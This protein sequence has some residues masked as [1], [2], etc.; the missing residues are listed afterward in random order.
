MEFKC[1]LCQITV[2]TPENFVTHF[3][4]THRLSSKSRFLCGLESCFISFL[5]LQKYQSHLSEFHAPCLNDAN[6]PATSTSSQEIKKFKCTFSGCHYECNVAST[7]RVHRKRK[8]TS[9][10]EENDTDYEAE[11]HFKSGSI[12]HEDDTVLASLDTSPA[13]DDLPGVFEPLVVDVLPTIFE[14]APMSQ[15]SRDQVLKK[16]FHLYLSLRATYHV[17]ESS[18]QYL[19]DSHYTLARESGNILIDEL[20]TNL[21][22]CGLEGEGLL[23]TIRSS[24]FNQVALQAHDPKGPLRSRYI[25]QKTYTS[26]AFRHVKPRS[27]KLGLNENNDIRKFH[28]VSIKETIQ[29]M[30]MDDSVFEQYVQ[31]QTMGCSSDDIIRDIQDGSLFKTHPVLSKDKAAIGV[32]MYE[33]DL[34][35]ADALKAARGKHK[36]T[37][38]EFTLSNLRP[39][40]RMKKGVIKLALLVCEKDVAYFGLE[41]A[42]KPLLDELKELSEEGIEIRGTKVPFVLAM[43]LGD[44]LGTH[45]FTGFLENFS[46]AKF[47]CRFCEETRDSWK[48]RWLLPEA[49]CESSDEECSSSEDESSSD[50]CDDSLDED[51]V[52]DDDEEEGRATSTA[53]E[54]LSLQLPYSNAPLRTPQ[55]YDQCL[56]DLQKRPSV[57]SVKGVVAK[58]LLNEVKNF[59]CIGSSP[60]C[61][62]HDMFEGV[63]SHDVALALKYF[64]KE[65]SITSEY[66]NRRIKQLKLSGSDQGDRP[67]K[68]TDKMKKLRGGAVQNW[69]F[70]RFLPL[71]IGNKIVRKSDPVW[72]MIL[73]LIELSRMLTSPAMPKAS[74]PKLKQKIYMYLKLR[75]TCFPDVPLRPKHHYLEHYP[76]LIEMFGCLMRVGTLTFESNHRFFKN[77]AQ[78]KKNF[79][80]I[81]KTLSEEHELAQ[82]ALSVD[83]LTCNYPQVDDPSSY[84]SLIMSPEIKASVESFFGCEWLKSLSCSEKVRFHGVWYCK[85]EAIVT[86]AANNT[87]VEMCLVEAL[88]VRGLNCYAA[89]EHSLWEK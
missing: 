67:A 52:H 80:N 34:E 63:V 55:S 26:G 37:V 1:K 25:R 3:N 45:T 31:T 66:I 84:S 62:A 10:P 12:E 36:I 38:I 41:K 59:H 77:T 43:L 4:L 75:I 65:F 58:C 86:C 51:E 22:K 60:P 21:N 87:R 39:W 50:D 23:D 17:P 32:I 70:L 82:S 68:V 35:L 30:F 74:L 28:T 16:Y 83:L 15:V 20:M 81:T 54:I 64:D 76:E 85:G 49:D 61:I 57:E 33:D 88:F 40:S 14:E 71:L 79:K 44:N 2:G 27:H 11:K 72:Q 46:W 47:F 19:I 42:L 48:A 5:T 53:D 7:L 6:Q 73:R 89:G 18:I 69:N 24:V 29:S 13:A 8:H 78:S 9:F 56:D